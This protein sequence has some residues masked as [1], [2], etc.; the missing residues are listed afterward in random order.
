MLRTSYR[1]ATDTGQWSHDTT[2][3]N[4]LSDYDYELPP[5]LLAKEPPPRREDAKLMVI[6]RHERTISHHSVADLPQLL[7]SGDC[8]VLNNTKVVPARLFGIRT[9]TGGKW[10][11]LFL[12]EPEPG[13]W[14]LIGETRGKPVSYTHLTLPT[15]A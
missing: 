4:E 7:S 8:L 6:R 14:R 1:E 2:S 5:E 9:E 11:G 12:D 15:K 3:M 10:E 13:T